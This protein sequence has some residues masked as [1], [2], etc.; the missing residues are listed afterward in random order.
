MRYGIKHNLNFVLNKLGHQLYGDI[1][2]VITN[3][4]I[5][6][7]YS[8]ALES[9]GQWEKSSLQYILSPCKIQF[10]EN[11]PSDEWTPTHQVHYNTQRS[12]WDIHI[13]LALLQT[14]KMSENVNRSQFLHANIF[15]HISLPGSDKLNI[16]DRKLDCQLSWIQNYVY[17]GRWYSIVAGGKQNWGWMA[18]KSK[19]VFK[20]NISSVHRKYVEKSKNENLFPK[21]KN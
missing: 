19:Y 14:G 10:Q 13:S 8:R 2:F 20:E 15:C 7:F 9:R 5:A 12:C 1:H 6:S 3:I 21:W 16:F 17:W 11:S 4:Y 18:S